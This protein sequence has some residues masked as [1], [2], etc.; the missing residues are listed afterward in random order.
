MREQLLELLEPGVEAMGF[1]LVDIEY[2]TGGGGVV[3]LYID[4][5]DGITV[6]DCGLVSQQVSGLLDV[7]DPVPGAYSL[8]VSSP[9]LKR[10]LRKHAHYEAQLGRN[11][12]VELG[13]ALDGR[14]RFKGELTA[15]NEDNIVVL[16]DGESYSLPLAQVHRARLAP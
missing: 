1:E 3:R 16:V 6:D 10:P 11:V 14:R 5:A 15:V 12:R 7:E 8:E 2:I 9:G 4:H 13:T